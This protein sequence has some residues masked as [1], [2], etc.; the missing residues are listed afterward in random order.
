M[1][2]EELTAA[3]NRLAGVSKADGYLGPA[4]AANLWAGT[5]NLELVGALNARFG[6]PVDGTCLELNGILQALGIATRDP[7]EALAL[8][9]NVL[10]LPGVS[11][12]YV[13]TPD[14]SAISITGDIDIRAKVAMDRWTPASAQVVLGK[15]GDA[16]QRGWYMYVQASGLLGAGISN[17][18]TVERFLNSGSA[19][20]FADGAVGWIRFTRVSATGVYVF[21]KS[22]DGVNWTS[23][24]GGT[25]TTGDLFDNTETLK[26]GARDSGSEPMLGH[27]Y[28][29]E[30]RSGIDGN[31]VAN[32]DVTKIPVRGFASPT[33]TPVLPRNL[34]TANQA[35]VET[36]TTGFG[37]TG[38]STLAQTAVAFNTG[39]A[40]LEMTTGAGAN[41]ATFLGRA[42]GVGGS[43]G[44]FAVTPGKTYTFIGYARSLLA[45]N[46][47]Q[48]KIAWYTSAN[49][50]ISQA[51]A[52]FNLSS[53][54]T[55][56]TV[57]GV[58]PAT[59][60][61]GVPYWT[62]AGTP[63]TGVVANFDTMAF[64]EG[65]VAYWTPPTTWTI[66]GTAW[67][68]GTY[69]G[70]QRYTNA[71]RLPNTAGNYAST[72]DSAALS[73]TGDID[74]RAKVA[75][76]DWTPS[77]RQMLVTKYNTTG[78]QRAYAFS[79]TATGRLEIAWSTDGT[80]FSTKESTVAPTVA[81][82]G[83]LWIRVTLDVDN[84]LVGHDVK[85]YTSSDG[86]TWT[87]LGTTV[88]TALTTS[89]FDSTAA[90]VISGRNDGSA[91]NISGRV[92]YAEIRNG[93]AG[94][95]VGV[96]DPQAVRVT[97]TRS[98][99]T[100]PSR[101]GETWTLNGTGWD[102]QVEG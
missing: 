76:N 58:A 45:T 80:A 55:L 19:T 81:D 37:A 77:A 88:T 57:S 64:Y 91:E 94:T 40:S 27:V 89:I 92:Y 33:T 35:D 48:I 4:G 72:P 93:I 70:T 101:T 31:V 43:G 29:A 73:I 26:I 22:T 52:S 98:P 20:D 75:L 16:G 62:F 85:F 5:T 46:S 13:S 24:T 87:Q 60:A 21:Y 38:G 42:G 82:G 102:W 68:W 10:R 65:T 41:P 36:D 1:A 15:R 90:A 18:G 32:F 99:T 23:L 44:T 50:F 47:L 51:A 86:V 100:V 7:G 61:W 67:W 66:N 39:A 9:E 79:L 83:T 8:T 2:Q 96:F 97:D 69:T 12:N 17:D 34:L 53:T 6:R 56:R 28:Y 78:N 54:W 71:L 63:G 59:A 95:V 25:D 14:N 30:V 11:G 84:G 49:A 74:I 3:L